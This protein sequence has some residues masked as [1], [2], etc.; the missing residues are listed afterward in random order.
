MKVTVH[1]INGRT[2][3]DVVDLIRA[4]QQKGNQ[5]VTKNLIDSL[6]DLDEQGQKSKRDG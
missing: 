1:I 5:I 3:V 4:L 2:C 6:W